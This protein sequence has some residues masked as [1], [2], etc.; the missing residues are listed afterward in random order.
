MES[1]LLAG[2]QRGP[3]WHNVPTNLDLYSGLVVFLCLFGRR[4]P[5]NIIMDSNNCRAPYESRTRRAFRKRCLLSRR[6][7]KE[8]NKA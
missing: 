4:M 2:E 7:E 3:V 6:Y 5:T 8:D 1:C